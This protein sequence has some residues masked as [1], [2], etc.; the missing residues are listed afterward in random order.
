MK[1]FAKMAPPE[2]PEELKKGSGGER[3]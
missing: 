1:L 2:S 3:D